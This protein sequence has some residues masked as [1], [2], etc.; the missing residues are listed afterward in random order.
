VVLY[1]KKKCFCVFFQK[2][3]VNAEK[4]CYYSETP[5]IKWGE[6]CVTNLC[7]MA[8]SVVL[9]SYTRTLNRL[10][11]FAIS[12]N[13]AEARKQLLLE[14]EQGDSSGK[15]MRSSIRRSRGD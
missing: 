6:I 2:Y 14:Q 4:Q 13:Q 1:Q 10:L 8:Q 7:K 5:K 15:S 9:C 12:A 3:Y 11:L